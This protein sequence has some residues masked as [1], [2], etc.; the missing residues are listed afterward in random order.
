MADM[1]D[2]GAATS[3]ESELGKESEKDDGRSL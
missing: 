2:H 1:A 3:D